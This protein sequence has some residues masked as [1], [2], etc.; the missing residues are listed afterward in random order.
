M[1]VKAADAPVALVELRTALAGALAA[2][3]ARLLQR[4]RLQRDKAKSAHAPTTNPN[5]C[6]ASHKRRGE[7]RRAAAA[8]QRRALR[9]RKCRGV[10]RAC[11]G[12]AMLLFRF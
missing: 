1:A 5:S 6:T 10:R 4:N 7:H 12:K 9:V 8:Q 11:R 2:A 3:L